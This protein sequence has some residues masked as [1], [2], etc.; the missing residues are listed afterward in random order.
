MCKKHA[1]VCQQR[2]VHTGVCISKHNYCDHVTVWYLSIT[3]MWR[4]SPPV[5]IIQDSL[6]SECKLKCIGWKCVH[7]GV[8][9]CLRGFSSC[10]INCL[11]I[12]GYMAELSF[13]SVSFHYYLAG[14]FKSGCQNS[15]WKRI[16]YTG[17][18]TLLCTLLET[19]SSCCP[20]CKTQ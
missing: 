4:K 18:V 20:L 9:S 13:E 19:F 12:L 16:L 11:S 6:H 1:S 14:H 3:W 2:R 15:F 7:P 8:F 10:M 5:F 17:R